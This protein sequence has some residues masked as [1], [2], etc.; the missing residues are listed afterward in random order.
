M[1][2]EITFKLTGAEA[3]QRKLRDF[4][5]K[6]QRK[7][8]RS[9]SRK[10]MKPV[11]DSARANAKQF[12]DPATGVSIWRQIIIK[13]GKRLRDG[14]IVMRVGVAGGAR[15]SK[16][17]SPPWYWRL[18]EFGTERMRA[19]PFMRPALENNIGKVADTFVREANAEID[20]L[21]AGRG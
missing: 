20:K 16:G 19:R 9:A 7:G 4:A 5:P 12:D 17:K 8:V 13:E 6:M 1:S 2:D 11:L 21:A 15:S 10:G 14:S 18:L 3:L